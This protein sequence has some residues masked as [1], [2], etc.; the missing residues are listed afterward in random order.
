M[1]KF[2]GPSWSPL[3]VFHEYLPLGSS[4]GRSQQ[5]SHPGR[6]FVWPTVGVILHHQ[7]MERIEASGDFARC[8]NSRLLVPHVIGVLVIHQTWV[9]EQPIL[10]F[11]DHLG[12]SF[13]FFS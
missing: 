9:G 8:L 11:F 1:N 6:S 3:A 13:P 2:V 10:K 4:R 12:F 5:K 7:V